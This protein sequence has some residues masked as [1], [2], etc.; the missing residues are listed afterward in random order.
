MLHKIYGILNDII[1]TTLKFRLPESEKALS[2]NTRTFQF[3]YECL[4][5]QWDALMVRVWQMRWCNTTEN[6]HKQLNLLCKSQDVEKAKMRAADW[7]TLHGLGLFL[8]TKR[9]LTRNKLAKE[10][11]IPFW[12]ESRWCR[13]AGDLPLTGSIT[14]QTR[15]HFTTQTIT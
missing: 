5:G 4:E 9:Y 2:Q 13:K 14:I 6:V 3:K 10:T 12:N 15:K 8:G 7:A 11:R 1:R